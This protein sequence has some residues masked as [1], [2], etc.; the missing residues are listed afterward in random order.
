MRAA[1][2]GKLRC[3][4]VL[5]S[6]TAFAKELNRKDVHGLSALHLCGLNGHK[7]CFRFLID[8]KEINLSIVDNQGRTGNFS[9]QFLT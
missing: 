6:N 7:E 3:L 8:Q 5:S 2:Y 4:Q 9:N 1:E